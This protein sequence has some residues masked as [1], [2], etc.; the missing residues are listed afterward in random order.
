MGRTALI[1]A[2]I[3]LYELGFSC[4]KKDPDTELVEASSWDFVE[5]LI[6]KK[7]RIICDEAETTEDPILFF[8]N[9]K[10]INKLLNRERVRVERPTVEY[11]PNFRDAKA[12]EKVYKAGRKP[13]KPFHF[14]NI[15]AHL[16]GN[17]QYHVDEHGLEADDAMCIRQY[18][19][20]GDGDT[21]ICSRDKD[22]RQCPGYHFSW[23]MGAQASIGPIFIEPIGFIEKKGEGEKYANG[24]S[25]P[26]KLFGFGHKFFYSQLLMGDMVDNIGGLAGRGPVFAYNLL[27][28]AKSERECYELVAELY[29]KTYGDEWKNKIL[30]QSSLLWMVR[31]TNEDGSPVLWLPPQRS[32]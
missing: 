26:I 20:W 1:D 32:V 29:I 10:R 28:D 8:T 27:H 19:S 31:E 18:K 21:I 11:V 17:Y 3:T 24:K 30:E 12:V 22:V 15:L 23:E 5:D 4:E 7:L 9:T 14:Y 6:N 25:K 2:D 13:E 16:L